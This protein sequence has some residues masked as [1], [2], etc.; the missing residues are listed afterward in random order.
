MTR[1]YPENRKHG[2]TT[3]QQQQQ[4]IWKENTANIDL[5]R[6]HKLN[7]QTGQTALQVAA[8]VLFPG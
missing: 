8:A 2:T 4:Q 3:A 5:C 7:Q 6:S 1:L